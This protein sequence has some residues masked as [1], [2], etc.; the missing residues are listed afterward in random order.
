MEQE[1][2]YPIS[3][4]TD[5]VNFTDYVND[6]NIAPAETTV[7]PIKFESNE[8]GTLIIRRTELAPGAEP[9]QPVQPIQP[10]QPV[11]PAPSAAAMPT[12]DA[13]WVNGQLR[14]ATVYKIDGSNYFKLRGLGNALGFGV[15]YEAG[16]GMII[17][18][19]TTAAAACSHNWATRHAAEMG[20]TELSGG[21][22]QLVFTCDCG[23]SAAPDD[24][25]DMN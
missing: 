20:H 13:L 24:T 21:Y 18:T 2:G 4:P 19:E 17:N 1:A 23:F 8:N 12:N 11:Q 15:D 10:V 25:D 14:N 16:K 7:A 3:Y 9:V 6:P 22:Q 5:G